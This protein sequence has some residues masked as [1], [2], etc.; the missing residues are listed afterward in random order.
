MRSEADKGKTGCL[1]VAAGRSSRMGECKPLLPL[2]RETIL[3]AGILTMRKAGADPIV[4]VAGREYE[5]VKKSIEDLGVCVLYNE[6][7]AVT[8]MFDSVKMGL[9]AL[10]NTCSRVLF[11]PG[12]APLYSLNTIQR[13]LDEPS[14]VCIPY[15]EQ[16][17]GHPVCFSADLIDPIC[18]YSGERGLAGALDA[19]GGRT[20]VEC[21][22]PGAYMD[23]DT[24][25]D[26]EALKRYY[27]DAFAE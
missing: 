6:D 24:P 26:Y 17:T 20:F 9:A 10:K 15:W 23:A 3:R 21:P 12:D 7:Y 18:Q 13:L 25:E 4:V 8:Q 5:A 19:L 1:I 14:P 2:G 11:A 16:K 22:D 27:A